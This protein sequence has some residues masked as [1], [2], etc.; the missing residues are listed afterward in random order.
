MNI[1]AAVNVPDMPPITW[2]RDVCIAVAIVLGL[3]GVLLMWKGLRLSRWLL[4]LA[5]GAAG[6]G[7]VDVLDISIGELPWFVT[8]GIAGVVGALLGFLLARLLLALLAGAIVAAG[9][10]YWIVTNNIAK[11]SDELL[12]TFNLPE[13]PAANEWMAELSR[14]AQEYVEKAWDSKALIALGVLAAAAV[15]PILFALLLKRHAVIFITSLFGAVAA[16]AA[17]AI[18]AKAVNMDNDPVTILTGL[19]CLIAIGGLTI[20]GTTVQHVFRGKKSSDGD[21]DSD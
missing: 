5:G 20:L 1:L 17:F 21:S 3:L 16:V 19:Y 2:T 6:W 9:T 8:G 10:L 15:I 14:I 12:P 18:A 7:L 13:E 11:V 4:M